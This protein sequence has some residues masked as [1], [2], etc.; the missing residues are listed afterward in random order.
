[1]YD[2]MGPFYPP[3]LNICKDFFLLRNDT[4]VRKRRWFVV[5]DERSYD[6]ERHDVYVYVQADSVLEPSNHFIKKKKWIWRNPDEW[7]EYM[8]SSDK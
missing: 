2:L 4:L 8:E 5:K 7:M 1:M 3:V 6:I